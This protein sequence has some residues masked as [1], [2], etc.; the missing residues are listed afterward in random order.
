ME[1]RSSSRCRRGQIVLLVAIVLA[2]IFLRAWPSTGSDEVGYDERIYRVYIKMAQKE[3]IWNYPD[4]VRTYLKWQEKRS[5]AVVPPT[6]VGF[7]F[8]AIA[9]AG[10]TGIWM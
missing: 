7:L 8:P 1:D 9:F 10:V 4:V 5:E 6:R 2:G 3:G